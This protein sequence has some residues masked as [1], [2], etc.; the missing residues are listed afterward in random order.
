MQGE[1]GRR[2]DR[3]MSSI[4]C[5]RLAHGEQRGSFKL[6]QNRHYP[7]RFR[8]LYDRPRPEWYEYDYKFMKRRINFMCLLEVSITL[9]SMPDLALLCTALLN[10]LNSAKLHQPHLSDFAI[11]S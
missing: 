11:F 9:L 8:I 5:E 4:K 3:E 1:A 2:D 10:Q 6:E 7:N